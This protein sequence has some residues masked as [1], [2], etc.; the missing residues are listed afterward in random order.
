MNINRSLH[1]RIKCCNQ[2][3]EQI[4]VL[5][6]FEWRGGRRMTCSLLP[7]LPY[8][9]SLTCCWPP[10][11][12]TRSLPRASSSVEGGVGGRRGRARAPSSILL[13]TMLGVRY[14]NSR[15][16]PEKRTTEDVKPATI[17]ARQLMRSTGTGAMVR[18]RLPASSSFRLRSL[19]RGCSP[20]RVEEGRGK[21]V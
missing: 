16:T 19:W 5:L 2:N 13:M 6:P 4:L 3:G 15:S 12:A 21:D 9:H 11:R 8:V 14:S 1:F 10:L 17:R 18:R 20:P 7:R